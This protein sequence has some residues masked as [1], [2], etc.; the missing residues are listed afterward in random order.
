MS[1]LTVAD[2][3]EDVVSMALD[4]FFTVANLP[5]LRVSIE[6]FSRGKERWLGADAKMLTKIAGFRPFYMQ[7][8]KPSAYPVDSRSRIIADCFCPGIMTPC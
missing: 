3:S 1:N 2:Y 6:P 8:K 4:S 7:F 5:H